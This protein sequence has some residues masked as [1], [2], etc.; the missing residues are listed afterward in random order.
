MLRTVRSLPSLRLLYQQ[1]AATLKGQVQAKSTYSYTCGELFQPS[2]TAIRNVHQ[3]AKKETI[4]LD[5]SSEKSRYTTM[6]LQG[7]KMECKKRGLKVSGRKLDLVQR[8]VSQDQFGAENSRSFTNISSNNASSLSPPNPKFSLLDKQI[9]ESKIAEAIRRQKKHDLMDSHKKFSDSKEVRKAPLNNS[10]STNGSS[11]AQSVKH[12]A[13]MAKLDK[14]GVQKSKAS[15]E[16]R[17]KEERKMTDNKLSLDKTSERK[18]AQLKLQA[19]KRE[20]EKKASE[21]KAQADRRAAEVRLQRAREAQELK[22]QAEKKAAEKRA[23]E[24]QQQKQRE[25]QELKLQAEKKAAE[26]RVEMQQQK[27]REAEELKLQAEK[28]AAELKHKMMKEAEELKLREATKKADIQ[29]RE[30]VATITEAIKQSVI[31]QST[32]SQILNKAHDQ[33]KVDVVASAK[34]QLQD[35]AKL[36]QQKQQQQQQ[37]QQKEQRKEQSDNLNSRDVKFLTAFGLSTIGWWSLKESSI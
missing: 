31:K 3:T 24:M 7:L 12:S 18:S 10:A 34:R 29:T 15:E 21:L 23:V 20:A 36:V 25:A 19:Q 11:Q 16:A 27:Q 22:L 1:E 2:T 32:I 5:S 6:N 4:L 26:K 35:R 30:K 8:L 33:S 28:K 14:T 17:Y 37:Q 13:E 9:K